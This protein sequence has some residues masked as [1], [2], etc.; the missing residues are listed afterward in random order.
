[1]ESNKSKRK[2]GGR[3]RQKRQKMESGEGVV[4]GEEVSVADEERRNFL[5][6]TPAK[7]ER[8]P[9]KQGTLLKFTGLEC[10]GWF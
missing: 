3:G 4:W 1:M 6:T 9:S 10:V 2:E 7:S 8:K 5:Y